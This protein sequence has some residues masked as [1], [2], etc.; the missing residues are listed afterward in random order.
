[1][2][3]LTSQLSI[4]AIAL[5]LWQCACAAYRPYCATGVKHGC[6]YLALRMICFSHLSELAGWIGQS[7]NTTRGST[8]TETAAYDQTGRPTRAGSV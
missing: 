7:A 3:G 8:K 4:A 6:V 2:L 1:M 5:K